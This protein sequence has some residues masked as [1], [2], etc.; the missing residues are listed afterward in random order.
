MESPPA[1]VYPPADDPAGHDPDTSQPLTPSLHSGSS[2]SSQ[3]SSPH[4]TGSQLSP[5]LFSLGPSSS[6]VGS[7]SASSSTGCGDSLESRGGMENF[8]RAPEKYD[9][10]AGERSKST[11]VLA[12]A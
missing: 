4:G 12:S 8:L 2:S 3:T 6:L 11:L 5:L 1:V 7:S 9:T 10:D